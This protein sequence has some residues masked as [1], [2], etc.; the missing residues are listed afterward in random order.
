MDQVMVLIQTCLILSCLPHGAGLHF[1][2]ILPSA[3]PWYTMKVI[4]TSLIVNKLRQ[5]LIIY[6]I[7][8]LRH[9]DTVQINHYL[10][11]ALHP[12]LLSETISISPFLQMG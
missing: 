12:F 8:H 6:L 10:N 1:S 3:D 2:T 5:M 9:P 11:Q 4:N 7:G